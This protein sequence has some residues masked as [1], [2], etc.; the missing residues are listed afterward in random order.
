M[1]VGF[2]VHTLTSSADQTKW[3]VIAQLKLNAKGEVAQYK[4]EVA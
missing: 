4:G 1:R 3:Q 2:S